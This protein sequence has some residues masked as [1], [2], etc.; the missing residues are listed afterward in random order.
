MNIC[1]G[2][3]CIGRLMFAQIRPCFCENLLVC[4]IS[5]FKQMPLLVTK[6]YDSRIYVNMCRLVHFCAFC[7]GM[8]L[9]M[10]MCMS[11]GAY[12]C[13][14]KVSV[15]GERILMWEYEKVFCRICAWLNEDVLDILMP[16]GRCICKASAYAC[17]CGTCVG[18]H[19]QC[20]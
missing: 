7:I 3:I 11:V 15:A 12:V 18:V 16:V 8:H 20:V 19:T 6:V 9:S 4:K 2:S 5:Q 17:T 13:S 1:K 14:C 10:L